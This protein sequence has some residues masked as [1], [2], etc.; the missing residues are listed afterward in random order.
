[1]LL[2]VDEGTLNWQPSPFGKATLASSMPPEDALVVRADLERARQSL[3]LA[4]D[5]HITYLVTPIK[6]DL[7]VDW[8]M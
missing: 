6:E 4:T 3:V 2:R 5:L 1:M 7:R 8:E